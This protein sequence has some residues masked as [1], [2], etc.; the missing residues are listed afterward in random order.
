VFDQHYS[1]ATLNTLVFDDRANY[2][3]SSYAEYCDLMRNKHTFADQLLVKAAAICF[4]TQ[5][6]IYDKSGA[7]SANCPSPAYRRTFLSFNS[8]EF[9]TDHFQWCHNVS[10]SCDY[11]ECETCAPVS[12]R[13]SLPKLNIGFSHRQPQI[14]SIDLRLTTEERTRLLHEAHCGHTGHPGIKATVK[15]LKDNYAQ[16]RGMTAHV[17]Q[18]IS[19]CPT[20]NLARI[21]LNPA[22]TM[23]S[24]LRLMAAPLRRWH[25]DNTGTLE[26]CVHTGFTR[27]Q[28][29]I[30]ETT[31]YVQIQEELLE[32]K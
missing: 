10:D 1:G 3:P 30:C 8:Q 32:A 12:F 27:I 18:F 22:R 14:P 25:C 5:I 7:V 21:R 6:V 2:K 26:T 31:G 11:L 23:H 15:I 24:S 16:W 28:A 19:Q 20:C 9:D 4:G 13:F 17:A 29:A